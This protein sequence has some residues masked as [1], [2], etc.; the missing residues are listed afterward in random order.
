MRADFEEAAM[1]DLVRTPTLIYGCRTWLGK[2]AW[3]LA[4]CNAS[5]RASLR[6]RAAGERFLANPV[7]PTASIFTEGMSE[8]EVALAEAVATQLQERRIIKLA[9][10]H[11]S[12]HRII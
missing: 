1:N 9:H 10:Y 8:E 12:L 7:A 11:V 4:L 3:E 2:P 6:I 5:R